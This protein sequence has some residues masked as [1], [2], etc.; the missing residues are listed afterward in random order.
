M[1]GL[2]G[3]LKGLFRVKCCNVVGVEIRADGSACL[4]DLKEEGDWQVK[5]RILLPPAEEHDLLWQA[6]RIARRM[7]EA[8]IQDIPLVLLAGKDKVEEHMLLVPQGLAGNER[9]EAA[10]WELDAR[11]GEAGQD[12]EDYAV[13]ICSLPQDTMLWGGIV[14]R[15]YLVSV[16]AAFEQAG[17]SLTDVFVTPEMEMERALCMGMRYWENGTERRWGCTLVNQKEMQAGW[18]WP[19]VA[20]VVAGLVFFMSCAVIGWDSWMLYAARQENWSAKQ[21]MARLAS[22][23]NKMKLLE[24]IRQETAGKEKRLQELS[25]RNI[26]WYSVLVHL[27]SRT[28]EGVWLERLEF[29]GRD[30]LRLSGR[31]VSY[32]AVADY[33]KVFEED[34]EFFPQGPVLESSEEKEKQELQPEESISFQLSITL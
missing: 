10:Y 13:A 12:I 26:P 5:A 15:D 32:E 27:G 16:Q 19:L 1:F 7:E 17:V 9:Q 33:V 31:A 4:L 8:G 29:E 18:N 22:E 24:N 28:V 20:A 6:N 34:K 3:R 2:V 21:E 11:L 14:S 23:K 30:K 25:A